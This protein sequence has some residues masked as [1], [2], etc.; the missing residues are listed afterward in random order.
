MVRRAE[1]GTKIEQRMSWWAALALL[2]CISSSPAAASL[3]LRT[4]L[5]AASGDSE[6]AML[7][8]LD[9]AARE[10]V[11]DEAAD[12][13]LVPTESVPAGTVDDPE[14]TEALRMLIA[15]ADGLR[16]PRNDPKLNLLTREI[17]SWWG[18]GSRP[19]FSAATSRRRTM[20]V[21]N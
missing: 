10:T 14:G 8:S 13:S 3:A 19:S 21:S 1:G 16:G 2:R 7:A 4:R 5:E 6:E 12:D 15:E 20:W 9:L 11:M 18:P 17:S